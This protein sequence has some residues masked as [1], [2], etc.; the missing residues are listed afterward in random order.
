MA[1]EH[2]ILVLTLAGTEVLPAVA[3]ACERAAVPCVSSTFPWQV[4]FYGRGGTPQSPFHWTYHFCWGL[5]DIGEVF[6]DLWARAGV[7]SG[8]VGCLWNE[9]PQ[10]QWSRHQEHGVLPVTRARGYDLVEPHGYREPATD[11]RDHLALFREHDVQV[12][13]SAATG[14]DL[15]LFRRQAT[16]HGFRPHLITSSRWLAYPPV[17]RTSGPPPQAGVGTL[18]YW[19]PSHPYC[20]SLDGTTAA[21]LAEAYEQETGRQWLQPLGLAYALFEVAVHALSAAEDPT[22]PA[23]VASAVARTRLQTM[24]GTLDWTHGPVPNI[25][26]VAL[27]AGQWQPGTR[28]P[29]ELAIVDSRGLDGLATQAD[30]LTHS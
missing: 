18:V 5:D 3:D 17:A 9:G 7:E 11:F 12:V 4:Y 29:W 20:S 24:A 21:Q 25:A 23:S 14:G 16:E 27:A 30:L 26:T 6:S 22:D 10:G 8:P 1:Y 13:A 15:A 28:H 19:S 2:A